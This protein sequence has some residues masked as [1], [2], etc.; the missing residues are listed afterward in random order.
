LSVSVLHGAS[1]APVNVLEAHDVVLAEIG[2][3]LHLDE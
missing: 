3:G 2:A 1:V